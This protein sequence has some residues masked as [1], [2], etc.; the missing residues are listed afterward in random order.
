M[1]SSEIQITRIPK[2]TKQNLESMQTQ[3]ANDKTSV[4]KF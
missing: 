2:H 1:D 4:K 3:K